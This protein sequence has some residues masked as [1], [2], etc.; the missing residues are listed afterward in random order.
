[1]GSFAAR[2]VFPLPSRTSPAE[3][4]N[5]ID[6]TFERKLF[7]EVVGAITGQEFDDAVVGVYQ[8]RPK[9]VEPRSTDLRSNQFRFSR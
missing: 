1:M 5:R 7:C 3:S 4:V 9:I 2:S 8:F 6:R